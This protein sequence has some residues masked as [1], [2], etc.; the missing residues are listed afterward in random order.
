MTKETEPPDG[1]DEI[2]DDLEDQE[3]S[4][5]EPN[6]LAEERRNLIG[7]C[8]ED[9]EAIVALR[10]EVRELISREDN[11]PKEIFDL[12]KLLLALG[13]LPRPTEGISLE[14]DLHE[15][16]PNGESTSYILLLGHGAFRLEKGSWVI[17]DPRFGGDSV[18]ETYFE[19][20]VSG[21]RYALRPTG[22]QEW[23]REFAEQMRN[24]QVTLS[25]GDIEHSSGINWDSQGSDEDW[26]KLEH[27]DD[28]YDL[29]NLIGP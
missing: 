2:E 4:D 23:V 22:L 25:I 19:C 3:D 5:E 17:A 27:D 28:W 7:L 26:K 11:T 14:L 29:D 6:P 12:A 18:G 16:F 1:F 10:Q 20:E 15:S 9:R 21:Y 13:N 8:V 24:P